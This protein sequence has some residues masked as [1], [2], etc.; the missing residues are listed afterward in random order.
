MASITSLSNSSYNTSSIYGNRNVLSGLASGMDTESMIENAVSGIKLKIQNLV[1]KRTKIEWQQEAYRSIIDKAVNFNTKYTSYSSK[2]NLL[3]NSFFNN[4]V[5]TTTMGTFKDKIT[6][7]GKTTS[8]I[9]INAVKQMA[10]AATYT[11]SGLGGVGSD[12]SSITG[13][14]FDLTKELD[15]NTI[16]GSLTFQ[17]GG[18][19]GAS[20][21]INFDELENLNEMEGANNGEKLA[22]AINK[23]L[24]EIT[25]NY[26]KN[27]FQETTTADKAI[28]VEADPFGRL[29]FTDGLGNGNEVKISSSSG[30]IKKYAGEH[31]LTA[32]KEL[33][34]KTPAYEYLG[35]TK[36]EDGKWSGGKEL[37]ITF[38]GTTKKINMSDVM[39][40]I[41]FSYDATED[42]NTQ[43]KKALQGELDDAF[44][45]GKVTVDNNGGKLSFET[46]EGSTL[47]VGGSAAEAL[48]FQE[49]DSNFINPSKKLSDIL[50]D[51]GET[52]FTQDNRLKGAGG[53]TEHKRADGTSYYLDKAGN[54]VDKDGY[55]VDNDGKALYD[56][57]INGAHISVTE[58]TTLESMMNSIN[59]NSEAGV[60]VSYSK[61]TNEFKF[62]ATETGAN[63]K[64]EFGGLAE[65]LFGP[66]SDLEINHNFADNYG[67][68]NFVQ[69]GNSTR[70]II[71]FDKHTWEFTVDENMT[72]QD[73]AEEIEKG[74]GGQMIASY[75]EKT[76]QFTVTNLKGEKQEFKIRDTFF[77]DVHD[78]VIEPAVNFTAGQDA[79]MDVEIN[80]KRFENFT[81]ASN[82][83]DID[84]LTI[85]VKGE[86]N[87]DGA[88]AP[89]KDGNAYEA[90]TFNTTTDSDKIVDAIKSFIED[91]NEMATELKNAYS[92]LPGQKSNGGRYEPLTAEEEEQYSESE[93]KAYNE[94][95]KQGIL[96]GDSD[97]SSMYSKLLGAITPGGADG[98]TLREIGITTSYSNGMTTLSLD[99]D[100][101][102]S[103]LEGDPDKVRN[104]FTKTKEDG[105]S[106]NGL[107]QNLQNTLNS[108]VKTTGEPKGILINRAGSVK[109]PTSLNSNS[110]KSQIDNIDSQIDRW[111]KKMSDQIDRYTTKFSRLEQLIAE[112]NSQASSMAGLMGGAGG[113]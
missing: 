64:I 18:T 29:T 20:F 35:G 7:S 72:M 19:N 15:V 58:D 59:S 6:A 30:D 80:G 106:S 32:P 108:Y 47:S 31:V 109:A 75:D 34:E 97:L 9:K 40:K 54:R 88:N 103:A 90:I 57:E 13:E 2:T 24:S 67:L 12:V 65:N 4:A 81:R 61:L 99:E 101:L 102:R 42:K 113:Y 73:F 17:Y 50:G 96:F 10:K 105:S 68:G 107:M 60:K 55:R 77:D 84:G 85:N 8:D 41:D 43:F 28:K 98:Q 37:G 78:R 53:A 46:A 74:N 89:D 11:V 33:T 56:V 104:A 70:V 38:N 79:V 63:S 82:S 69:N 39:N 62:T 1:K 110:L 52:I 112:M 14:E 94:K 92:T 49:G 48:G 100:K 25:Y 23:K 91:Y 5:N 51:K 44:G 16:S 66:P 21:T 26:T 76:G 86:F 3:S 111:Q 45:K 22:N 36:D 93:L 71:E 83:F 27:G 87:A 95:A